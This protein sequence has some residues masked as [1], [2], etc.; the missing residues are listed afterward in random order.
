VTIGRD[1]LVDVGVP[2]GDGST[3]HDRALVYAGAT[4]GAGVFV[5]PGAILTN[6]RNPRAVV[7]SGT[8]EAVPDA[9]VVLEDGSTVGAAAVIVA[10]VRVGR[11]GFVGAGA[12]VTRDVPGHALVAGNPARRLGWVCGCGRRLVDANGDP[13]PPEPAHYSLDPALVCPA[14]ERVYAYVPDAETLEERT[15]SRPAVPA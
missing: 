9:T 1:A 15:P 6:E 2:V 12:V 11:Y 10:G 3:I 4:V 14:C 8:A 13:A 7:T 5:G